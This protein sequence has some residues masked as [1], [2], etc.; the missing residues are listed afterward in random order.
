[1][2]RNVHIFGLLI[3]DDDDVKRRAAMNCMSLA[4]LQT[5]APTVVRPPLNLDIL[6]HAAYD[7]C[8]V[9]Y[10]DQNCAN[11]ISKYV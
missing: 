1:M 2:Q 10:D 11:A 8:A 7:G 3:D 9:A 4:R 6:M 5:T